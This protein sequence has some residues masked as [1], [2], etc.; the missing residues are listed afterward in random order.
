MKVKPTDWFCLLPG[1][2]MAEFPKI[3]RELKARKVKSCY[4]PFKTG[5]RVYC[6]KRGH[7]KGLP[8]DEKGPYLGDDNSGHSMYHQTPQ[9]LDECKNWAGHFNWITIYEPEKSKKNG[10]QRTPPLASTKAGE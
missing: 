4:L 5:G 3:E 2:N 10:N 9:M 6:I 8:K 1:G 7:R